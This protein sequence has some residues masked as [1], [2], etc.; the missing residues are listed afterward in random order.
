VVLYGLAC[1]TFASFPFEL[2][3]VEANAIDAAQSISRNI[4]EG[5]GRRSLAEYLQHLNFALGSCAELHS[6]YVSF[7]EAR[8]IT[9]EH[10]EELDALHYKV[11]NALLKLIESLEAKQE[12]GEAWDHV[13]AAR[14]A[15]APA[16][17]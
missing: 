6:C 15:H 9:A 3:R 4:A 16:D 13:L 1:R 10:Y 5:Y 11:E 17:S 12:R 14:R 2:K 8:Q 7:N